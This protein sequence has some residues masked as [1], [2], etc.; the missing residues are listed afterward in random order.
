[1]EPLPDFRSP[2][3]IADALRVIISFCLRTLRFDCAVSTPSKL[4]E[5][6]A[7]GSNCL[8]S[9]SWKEELLRRRLANSAS[10]AEDALSARA[11]TGQSP[12]IKLPPLPSN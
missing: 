4:R 1:M 10:A 9:E 8:Y 7:K 6:A 3:Q 5:A 11:A 2:S 12:V